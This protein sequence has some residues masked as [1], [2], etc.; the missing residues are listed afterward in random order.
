[1]SFRPVHARARRIAW[2]V[3]S[4]PVFVSWRLSIVGTARR[5]SSARRIS[6]GVGPLPTRDQPR[7]MASRIAPFTPGSLWPRRWGANAA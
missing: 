3:A 5:S 4:L 1:M 7:S 6:Q 2:A